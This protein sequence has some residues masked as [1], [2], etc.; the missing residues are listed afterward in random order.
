MGGIIVTL[1]I[2]GFIV[3]MA[4]RIPMPSIFRDLI[5]GLVAIFLLIWVL[6]VLGVATGVPPLH[7]R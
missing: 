5:V 2:V 4:L 6:Q 3:Y 7:F 1:V